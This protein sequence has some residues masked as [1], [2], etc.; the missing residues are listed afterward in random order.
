MGFKEDLTLKELGVVSFIRL[1]DM[2][3]TEPIKRVSILDL[4]ASMD[5]VLTAKRDYN[6]AFVKC[7][8]NKQRIIEDALDLVVTMNRLAAD[9]IREQ[10]NI[11][12]STEKNA[13]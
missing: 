4:R 13:L 2:A 3:V 6:R 1:C 11:Q 9:K 8:A 7:D 10:L 5:I 12:S